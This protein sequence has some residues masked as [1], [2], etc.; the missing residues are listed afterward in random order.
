VAHLVPIRG[1]APPGTL[2]LVREGVNTLNDIALEQ[3]CERS[4]EL[5]GIHGSQS[6]RCRTEVT[7]NLR[8]YV[9]SCARDERSCL[10]PVRTSSRQVS[11]SADDGLSALDGR[12][13]GAVFGA[14]RGGPSSL[15]R[16]RSQPR[17]RAVKGLT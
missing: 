15:L 7:T 8:A 6:S 11:L 17:L 14:V 4:H 16:A 12:G 1:G 3:A 13:V 10:P 5:M 9:R 2:V